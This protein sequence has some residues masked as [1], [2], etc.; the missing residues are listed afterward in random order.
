MPGP[1]DVT[2]LTAGALYLAL[3]ALVFVE[4][5]LLV[6]F[7][8]PGDTVLFA[9]GLLAADPARGLS[10]PLLVAVV[11]VAAVSGDAL[12]YTLGRRLGRPYLARRD[13]RVVNPAR[14]A[15]AERFYDRFG[16]FAVVAARWIPWVRTLTPADGRRRPDAVPPVPG[17]QRRRGRH[18]GRRAAG[19]GPPRRGAA[20]AARRRPG[21]GRGVGGAVGRGRAAGPAP[22]RRRPWRGAPTSLGGVQ[23]P[24]RRPEA[25]NVLSAESLITTLGTL[26]VI[27]VIFAETGL[28]VG[29][30]LPGDS[31]LVT[32]GIFSTA[33][34]AASL[35][36]AQLNITALLIGCP[37][38]AIVG[39]QTGYVIGAKA[40]PRLFQRPDSRLFR[41]EYVSKAEHYFVRFGPAKAVVLARF[42][43]IVRTFLNPVA[44]IL[45][46][47]PR[48]FLFWQVL[49]GVVWTEGVLLVGYFLGQKVKGIDHYILP[50][51]VLIVIASVIPILLEIRRNRAASRSAD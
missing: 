20:A 29:F 19:A 14:L 5:G 11:L 50:G 30:F 41:A 13:N 32:A 43:P 40:G 48:T 51:V 2:T 28:L 47:P 18:L 15:R 9:V 26:G 16:P 39:A 36:G 38:A 35:G 31:L 21:R 4:S 49:G 23:P 44:G 25:L 12:G 6:G 10:L 45:A 33:A 17:G 22:L 46:M 1:G 24:R 8:L 37:I 42:V 27:A 7:F 34:G 3:F